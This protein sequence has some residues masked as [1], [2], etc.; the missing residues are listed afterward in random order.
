MPVLG[1][2]GLLGHT[3]KDYN[4]RN[5]VK[6]SIVKILNL[7]LILSCTHLPHLCGVKMTVTLC[8]CV[9][10]YSKVMQNK[11][12]PMGAYKLSS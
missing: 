11:G 1:S 12:T 8:Y 3:C 2:S 5:F 7:Y 6:L 9:A 4:L 10:H